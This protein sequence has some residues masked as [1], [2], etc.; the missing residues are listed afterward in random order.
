M[1]ILN[2]DTTVAHGKKEIT[3]SLYVEIVLEGGPIGGVR[4][5]PQ[6]G[7][8]FKKCLNVHKN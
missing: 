3:D 7:G 1:V 4:R 6:K 2:Y 8:S 5:P